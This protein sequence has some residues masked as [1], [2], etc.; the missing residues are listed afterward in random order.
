MLIVVRMTIFTLMLCTRF[1]EKRALC[2]CYEHS[3]HT[4]LVNGTEEHSNRLIKHA[5]LC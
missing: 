5:S 4:V 3:W 2:F 1:V